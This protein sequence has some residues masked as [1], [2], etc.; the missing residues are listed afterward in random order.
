[1]PRNTDVQGLAEVYALFDQLPTAAHEEMAVELG[2]IAR[3]LSAAQHADVARDTGALDNALSYELLLDRLKVKVGLL[4]GARGASTFNGR[5]FK[6]KAGGPFYG[7]I[8]EHGRAAQTVLV[9]RRIKKRRVVGNGRNGTTRRVILA[10]PKRKLRRRSSPNAGTF[11]GD[12]YKL[13]VK[14]KEG[15]P[16][17]AQ[18]LLVEVAESHL[19]NFWADALARLGNAR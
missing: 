19:S 9:T 12:P 16:F 5:S 6:G 2:V 13:R 14:A 10:T 7:R 11:V 4:R 8:V 3:E 17:V 18:P 1:M 15:R